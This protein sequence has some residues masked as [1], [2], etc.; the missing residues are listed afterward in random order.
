M[1]SKVT[2]LSL[3]SLLQAATA[4]PLYSGWNFNGIS[5]CSDSAWQ[6]L[7]TLTAGD[8]KQGC[9]TSCS[10]DCGEI[11]VY[12]SGTTGEPKVIPLSRADMDRITELCR[13]FSSFE[14]ITVRSR[15]MVLLPMGLWSVGK[16]TV[17]GHLLNDAHVFP[18][19]L[20]GDANYWNQL[21]EDIKPTVMS[22][23]PSVLAAWAPS[24]KGPALELVE[25]TGEPLLYHERHLIEQAFG[26]PVYDAYGLSECVVGVEC[27]EHLG[28]HYW[29]DAVHVEI[30]DPA[31]DTP[32][33]P[34][35]TGEIVVTNF[36]QERMPIIRYRTGDLGRQLALN[37]NCNS[38]VPL[39]FFEGRIEEIRQEK[40]KLKKE[41][42]LYMSRG[43]QVERQDL[44][45]ILQKLYIEADIRWKGKPGSP[46]ALCLG[47]QFTPTLELLLPQSSKDSPDEIRNKIFAALP[48]I[49]ELVY[50]QELHLKISRLSKPSQSQRNWIF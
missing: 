36:M 9:G 18:V 21:I 8:F 35:T 49:S 3:P 14:R 20:Q 12:S 31:S 33:P 34:N 4:H 22:S 1:A 2:M 32:L 27:S 10:N 47:K 19:N 30:L 13:R 48:E 26:A 6:T 7:P 50:E 39:L 17:E 11:L 46:A 45:D 43:V 40:N 25:T 16:I 5:S 41:E 29:P 38:Q 42:T 37:C 44:L 23:T 28:F 24:F 15:V